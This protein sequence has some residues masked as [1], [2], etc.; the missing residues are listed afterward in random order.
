M[1]VTKGHWARH[2]HIDIP[3]LQI[4]IDYGL[5]SEKLVRRPT[6]TEVVK[7][8]KLFE[9]KDRSEF[10]DTFH[11]WVYNQLNEHSEQGKKRPTLSQMK[12]I[13]TEKRPG[14][15]LKFG[16]SPEDSNAAKSVYYW[17]DNL[18][19]ETSMTEDALKQFILDVTYEAKKD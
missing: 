8:K 1:E 6:D 15:F 18:G 11:E 13:I 16:R 3:W 5:V 12:K 2:D 9:M 4:A 19:E 17:D 14:M 10:K 7:P